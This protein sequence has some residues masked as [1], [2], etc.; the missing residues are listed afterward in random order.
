MA[1]SLCLL[2]CSCSFSLDG[3]LTRIKDYVNGDE[4]ELRPADFVESRESGEYTYDAYLTYAVITKYRGEETEVTVPASIDGL[5]VKRVGSLA[6][7]TCVDVTSIVL[8]E[9]IEAVE[10]NAF[11]YCTGLTK[12]NLPSTLTSLGAKSFSWCSALTS[13]ILPDGITE[14]P[15]FCFNQCAALTNVVWKG[16]IR[17]VG[18]RAFSGCTSL[19][20]AEFGNTL[21]SVGDFAFRGD[22]SLV[23]V[24]LPGNCNLGEGVFDGIGESLTAVVPAGS[25]CALACEQMGVRVSETAPDLPDLPE[26][27]SEESG[28][29]DIVLE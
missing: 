19:V 28:V 25:A 13:V 21:L 24:R 12:I 15:E 17:T 8:P 4:T 18:A 29:S 5:P 20:S 23:Y 11:Y 14:I 9:G 10:D 1:F 22:T 2:L 26:E 7:Y 6:F 27:T 16:D 3:L